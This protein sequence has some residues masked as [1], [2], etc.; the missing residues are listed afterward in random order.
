MKTDDVKQL[1]ISQLIHDFQYNMDVLRQI[2]L[3]DRDYP[4]FDRLAIVFIEFA[5]RYQK[6]LNERKVSSNLSC[7]GRPMQQSFGK[8][9][10]GYFCTNC[11][12]WRERC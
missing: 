1:D 8:E 10:D 11:A 12:E 7:C 3:P 9:K 2:E 5:H 4:Q 6:L